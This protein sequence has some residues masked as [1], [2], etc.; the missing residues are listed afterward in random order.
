M[1]PPEIRRLSTAQFAALLR[2]VSLTRAIDAVHLH[3]TWRPTQAQFRGLATIEAM[4]NVHVHTNGWDDIAQHLTIDPQGSV[5][6]G[7][8]WNSPPASQR[9]H[10]GTRERGPFMIEIVGDF[11]LGRDRL[12]GAQRVAVVDVVAALLDVYALAIDAVRFH[13][14]LSSPKTCPGSGVD[15]AALLGDIRSAKAS[16]EH[17]RS[18]AAA[19]GRTAKRKGQRGPAASAL[20]PFDSRFVIGADVAADAGGAVPGFEQWEIVEADFAARAVQER[21]DAQVRVA[22]RGPSAMA[23]VLAR[24]DAQWE[25]LRPHVVNL[26][27]GRLSRGGEF[28]MEPDS[29][30][31]IIEAIRQYAAS[32]A[33]PRLM[34]HAHGGLINEKSALTYALSAHQWWLQHGVYPVYFVWETGVLDV[35]RNQ[36]GLSRDFGERRDQ[37]FE[38]RVRPLIKPL[39]SEMKEYALLSSSDDA[40]DGEA[41]GARIF[42]QALATLVKTPPPPGGKP[43][44][45]HAVGHSAGAIFHTHFVPMLGGLGLTVESLALLA[46]AVRIDLFKQ[47]LLPEL[48]ATRLRQLELYTMDEEAE[49]DDDLIELFGLPIYG[50]SL[51]YLV[52]RAFEPEE[53]EGPL[54]GLEEQFKIDS[55]VSSLFR[56]AGPHRLELSHA[57]GKPHN[58]AT[59]AR[60][61]GCFDNDDAT[62]RSVL[63]TITGSI[64]SHPFT[65]RDEDCERASARARAILAASRNAGAGGRADRADTTAIASG[66]ASTAS[67]P[68]RALCV[69]ID[70][71]PSSPLAGCVRDAQTWARTLEGLRFNV[72]TILDKDATRARI[73][74]ALSR[75]VDSARPGDVLVFQYAGHGTQVDDLNGDESDRFDEALVPVDVD[76]GAL[77][78]DDDLADVYRRLP[79]GAMLTLFMDCC[80]SGTNSR[81]APIGRSR[82]DDKVRR[83]FLELTAEQKAAH[84]RFRARAG[85]PPPVTAEE[86]LPGVIHFAACLDNQFAFESEGQGH[87]TKIATRELA[88]AVAAGTTNENFGSA[89]A[90]KVIELGRPQTPQLLRL[91]AA[92]ADRPLFAGSGGTAANSSPVN[93]DSAIDVMTTDASVMDERCLQF[94][95]AGAA[96]W[97]RRLGK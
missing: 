62:M 56:P 42:A 91:P 78:L 52:S 8:N 38:D 86:S 71:Y 31:R 82:G 59:K 18:G 34:L 33:T 92:A 81:F 76:T 21:A 17:A 93:T 16:M 23:D 87:F 3:H 27:E 85:S 75:L 1:M 24:T 72:Q 32:T 96:H 94:F 46:P 11:D 69:G 73:L 58:P 54:L 68:G 10:N 15:K 67:R 4:R 61:H 13:R 6:T 29:I 90:A 53:G 77:V 5:W 49:K 41:G 35:I 50:K 64:T 44:T 97:R 19:R 40:G 25:P 74:E 83:R 60:K 55:T 9:G 70:G 22:M 63:A 57:R 36:L 66:R 30:E 47:L 65:G 89:V 12:D 43:I 37:I 28:E 20:V 79:A 80:H 7:R 84:R 51:L 26:T 39:W 2:T 48:T 14:E 45:L 95:E 88:A